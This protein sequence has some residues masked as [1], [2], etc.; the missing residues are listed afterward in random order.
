MH[1]QPFFAFK[2][3]TNISHW[4]SQSEQRGEERRTKFTQSDA[5][6]IAD[7]GFDHIRLPIDEVQ[8][9]NEA[10]T[11]EA[12]AFDL[13]DS[14]LDWAEQ[15]GLKV[16]VDLHI[17][18]SHFF[19]SAVEPKLF[20]DPAEAERFGNLW[21]Q[22]SARLNGRSNDRVAYELMNEAV[23]TN[24]DD[25]NRVAMV[26]FQAIR[27]LEPERSIVLGSNR[28]NS[29]LTFDQLHVPDDKR[30]ILTF[31]FY[32][33][34]LVTHHK[35]RWALEGRMYDGP[36]QY[37]GRPIPDQ[38]LSQVRM[39][40]KDRLL[41]LKI[42]EV[43][44]PYDRSS[45][46]ADMAKPLAVAAKTGLPLYCGEFG[47]YSAAPQHVREAWYRDVISAFNQHGIAWANWDYR[48]DFGIVD[49]DRQSTGIAEVMLSI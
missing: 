4:L 35:A 31:H 40:E 1:K 42:E 8:M 18:R 23:A 26:A 20:S 47:V 21:R 44:K 22:L 6:R 28:W 39:P 16:V 41:D 19:I 34:M 9:W 2:R 3:G 10:G 11:Q 37:P 36:I 5:N 32:L 33:P 48:G 27:E 45:M 13:M 7:W 30:T 43:N 14:A 15:A 17:L 24:A 12:E 25:W 38:Y 46:I 49:R 29:A